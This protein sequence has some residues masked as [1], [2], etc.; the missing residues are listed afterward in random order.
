MVG[1]LSFLGGYTASV[2]QNIYVSSL[3]ESENWI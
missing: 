2:T 1:T 3:G